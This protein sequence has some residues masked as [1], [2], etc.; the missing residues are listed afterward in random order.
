MAKEKTQF[1][2][3][4][5]GNPKGRPPGR[6]GRNTAIRELLDPHKKD[7]VGKAVALAMDG[8]TTALRL[9]LERLYPPIKAT[10]DPVHIG[11]LYQWDDIAG[12]HLYLQ[13]ARD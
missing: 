8:D 13:L 7:L 9:C 10:D 2:P 4:Q 12:K 1:K 3:G 5:S 6:K 11:Q